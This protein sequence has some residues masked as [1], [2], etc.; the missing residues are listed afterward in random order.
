MMCQ[1]TASPMRHRLTF[2]R[3][4]RTCI[5]T[6]THMRT[7]IHAYTHAEVMYILTTHR[8]R[9]HRCLPQL[10]STCKLSEYKSK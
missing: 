4:I 8:Y 5:H 6:Y 7:Y 2:N 1:G 3:H 10:A 9:Q